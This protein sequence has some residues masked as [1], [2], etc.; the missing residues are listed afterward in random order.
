MDRTKGITRND[1]DQDGKKGSRVIGQQGLKGTNWRRH[2]VNVWGLAVMDTSSLAWFKA[3]AGDIVREST[4][5]DKGSGTGLL[6][7]NANNGE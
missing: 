4:I 1:A 2:R 3:E 5:I 6:S 7:A